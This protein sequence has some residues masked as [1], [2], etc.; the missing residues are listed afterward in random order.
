[1]VSVTKRPDEGTPYEQYT[2][3][4]IHA[5][6]PTEICESIRLYY[7]VHGEEIQAETIEAIEHSSK[8]HV[9][10]LTFLPEREKTPWTRNNQ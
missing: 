9:A 5:G 4:P 10:G 7:Q 1:M 3:I 6:N 8:T 2:E